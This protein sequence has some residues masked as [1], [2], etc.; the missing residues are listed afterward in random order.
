[1]R[2]FCA[3]SVVLLLAA[4]GRDTVSAPSAVPTAPAPNPETSSVVGTFEMTFTADAAACAG[5]PPEARS[6]TYT[7][8][9][10][11]GSSLATLTGAKFVAA[12]APY[13]NWNVL[14]TKVSQESADMMFN[15]PPIWEELSDESYVVIYGN[16]QGQIRDD[17]TLPFWARF[18]Y[19]PEREPDSYPECEVPAT[20][21]VSF[22]H[23]LTLRRK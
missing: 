2:Q 10:R 5:L 13:P 6:R 14:Y 7:A 19:C 22:N 3:A 23:Q 4:C 17:A 1:M 20:T 15:D 16:A 9:F 12:G 21:C 18:E 11:T 8:T